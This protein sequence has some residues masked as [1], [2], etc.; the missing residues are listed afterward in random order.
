[1]CEHVDWI[2]PGQKINSPIVGTCEH[3]NE[4]VP[5]NVGNLLTYL[6]TISFWKIR[7]HGKVR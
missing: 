2:H 3:D 1:M 6:T 4:R 5:Q 7:L